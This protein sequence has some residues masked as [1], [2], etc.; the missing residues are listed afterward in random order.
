MTLNKDVA[1]TAL[2]L[3]VKIYVTFVDHL[4]PNV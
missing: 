4:C 3:G 2:I 1:P